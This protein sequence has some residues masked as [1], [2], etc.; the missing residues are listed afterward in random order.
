[1]KKRK[2]KK[3]KKIGILFASILIL[4]VCIYGLSL[5]AKL[6]RVPDT[7]LNSHLDYP[8]QGIDVSA[9]QGKI[10]WG[11]LSDQ[12]IAFAFIKATEGSGH[13][14]EYFAYNWKESHKTHLRVGAYHFMSF[15]TPGKSQ[16]DNFIKTVSQEKNMLPPVIDVELYGGFIQNPPEAE[17]VYAI[18]NPLLERVEK[19]YGMK[20]LLYTSGYVY[21][22]YLS[23]RYEDHDIWIADPNLKQPLSDQRNWKFCQYSFEGVLKGYKGEVQH[24]D[25]NV[26]NGSAT[27]FLRYGK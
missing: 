14:D 19:E 13:V 20:P 2:L 1:M 24:I 27:E 9:Y 10:D 22:K 11:T 17:A 23:G 3:G 25:L 4:F 7:P 18:L 12:G 16:A 5:S 26:F 21:D 15:E 6:S 8:V